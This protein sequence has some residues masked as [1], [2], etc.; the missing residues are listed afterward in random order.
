MGKYIDRIGTKLEGCLSQQ[1][2]RKE[3]KKIAKETENIFL[4]LKKPQHVLISLL[5]LSFSIYALKMN[6][7]FRN[8]NLT[9]SAEMAKLIAAKVKFQDFHFEVELGVN[10]LGM[11]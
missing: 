7:C 1:H 4:A 11:P 2:T 8:I 3:K 10:G 5:I 6:K 9:L